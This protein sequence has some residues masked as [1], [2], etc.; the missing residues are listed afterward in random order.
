MSNRPLPATRSRQFRTTATCFHGHGVD[1]E[2]ASGG[3]SGEG[4]ANMAGAPARVQRLRLSLAHKGEMPSGLWLMPT[5]RS[6]KSAL[7]TVRASRSTRLALAFCNRPQKIRFAYTAYREAGLG[8]KMAQ[9]KSAD[10]RSRKLGEETITVSMVAAVVAAVLSATLNVVANKLAPL[11]IKQYSSVV[12][13]TKD[14]EELKDLVK[15]VNCLLVGV[16]YEAVGN[17]PPLDWLRK[18]KDIAYTVDDVVDEFQLKAEEHDASLAAGGGIIFNMLIKPKSFIFQCKA[19][20]K[21]K[22]IKKEFAAI[23]KK[24]TDVSAIVNSL[25]PGQ[26]VR[27]TTDTVV[28]PS[29]PIVNEALVLG[30]DKEKKKIMFK[31]VEDCDQQEI[32]VVSIIGLGGSGKTTLAKLVFNDDKIIEKHFEV[33]LWVHVSQEFDVQNKLVKKLFEAI[34]NENS[35]SHSIQHMIKKISNKLTKNRFLLVLD[36]VWTEN[37]FHWETFMEY[38]KDGAPGS[39]IL[40]TTRNRNV[41]EAVECTTTNLFNLPFLSNT[42][43]WQ[44]F[45]QS[46]GIAVKDLD[47]EF[48]EV[49][50][51]IVNK[52][53]GVPLAI[54]VLAGV[55]RVKKRIEQWH[56][57][58]ENN[59]LYAEDKERQV[60]ACLSL[61]YYSLPS[62]LKPC[63]T[64]CSLFPKG[65]LIHKEQLIDQWIAHDMISLEVDVNYLENTGDDYFNYLVQMGFLQ[66]VDE[67]NDGRVKCRMHDLVHDLSR[68]ILGDEISLAVPIERANLT[69]VHR[70]FSLMEQTRHPPPKNTFEKARSMYVVQGYDFIFGKALENAKHLRSVTVQSV[71]TQSSLRAILQIKN[72]RYLNVSGL[73]CKRF[74]VVISDIWGLEALHVSSSHL[75]ELPESIGKLHKLR[76]VH[77]SYCSDLERELEEA[78]CSEPTR[79][80]LIRS[81]ANRI[82]GKLII[83]GI[84]CGMDPNDGQ[85]CLKEKTNLQCL[86]L[87]WRKNI[88]A[89]IENEVAVLDGLE[90]PSGI[91]SLKVSGYAGSTYAQWMLQQVSTGA[92]QCPRF[93]WLR[94]LELSDSPNLKHLRGLVELPRLEKLVLSQMPALESIS[95]GPFPALVDLVMREMYSLGVV[96]VVSGNL[97]D[98]VQGGGSRQVWALVSGQQARSGIHVAPYRSG[99]EWKLL[100]HLMALEP[101]EIDECSGLIEL[102]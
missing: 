81:Y 35:E 50:K 55:L 63:F 90:P 99:C 40:L 76:V 51:D 2:H 101:L 38:V 20:R 54:K 61:S 98:D 53:G 9:T 84:P 16:G 82:G 48:L 29:L 39:K 60:S 28:G 5:T 18:L 65:H 37:R 31:L 79:M 45:Q 34:S 43:S 102:P 64:I 13:V 49:G 42:Y 14:L 26:P 92:A 11:V 25:P 75:V 93:P 78:C 22:K 46:F 44:V 95:G 36:D 12:G 83:H 70:Y 72:L 7:G 21:V 10:L 87:F 91:R 17:D 47:P 27:L 88:A 68:S 24:R 85:A 62:Y 94:R 23:V 58:R 97:A 67:K 69:K 33:R 59:L 19:A 57:V 56:A 100:Q 41:A 30:R 73:K 74:P 52:C 4:G 86:K 3:A 77:L 89:N 6:T 71:P 66:D 15:E 32:K 8:L 1:P 80:W 96:W